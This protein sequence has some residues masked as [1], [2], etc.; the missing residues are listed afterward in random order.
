MIKDGTQYRIVSEHRGSVRL[1]VNAD[2]GSIAQRLDY[3]PFGKVT[4]NANPGFC[5]RRSRLTAFQQCNLSAEYTLAGGEPA[6]RC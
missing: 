1:V 3:T 6:V 5:Q 2:T 4:T